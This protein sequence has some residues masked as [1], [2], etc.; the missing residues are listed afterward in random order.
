MCPAKIQP[1][2]KLCTTCYKKYK[3]FIYEDWFLEIAKLQRQQDEID[4]RENNLLLDITGATI[5][6]AKESQTA[7]QK[8]VGRPST[9]WILVNEVL[10]L[11]DDSIENELTGKGKRLSLRGIQKKMNFRVKYLTVRRILLTY[12]SD[13]YPKKKDLT[14]V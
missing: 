13:T 6:G 2:H 10:R 12:R 7:L 5:F 9:P 1:R 8:S 11:Y 4:R 3:S 14:T